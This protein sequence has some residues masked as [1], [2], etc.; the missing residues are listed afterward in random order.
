MLELEEDSHAEDAI[1]DSDS[2]VALVSRNV[3]PQNF[4]G[5]GQP[6]NSANNFNNRGNSQN[7]G[8]ENNR[9]RSGGNLNNRGGSSNGQSSGGGSST[10][11]QAYQPA[12]SQQ[13]GPTAP[14][15]Y[16]PPWAAWG[17]Q[18]WATPPCP[19]PTAGWQ[20]SHPA[21]SQ[22]GVLGPRPPQSFYSSASSS[23]GGY[24]PTDIDQAMHT[25]SLNPPDDKNWYMDTGATSHMTNSQGHPGN[26]IL[27]SLRSSNLIE[28]NKA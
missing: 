18:P 4:S 8:K 5:N 24:A 23:H 26:V 2:N 14:S 19:Y 27:S 21:P 17:Q 12:A 7:R 11:A 16:F 6:N 20:Q 13:Q 25:M 3:T 10:N 9:G 1:H 28:C 22:Q 15:W